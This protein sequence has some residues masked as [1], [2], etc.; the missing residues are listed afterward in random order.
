[1]ELVREYAEDNSEQA[2]ATLVSQHVNLVYSVALR[3]V[4]DPHLAEEIT[5]GVFIILAR[6]AKSLSPKTILSG[7]LCRTAR[8]V[9]AHTL[10]DQRRRQ[11]REQEAQMQSTL[12]ESAPTEWHQMAPL[13]DEALG[14][15]GEKEQDAVML[16][17]FEGKELSRVGAAMGIREDAARMRVNRGLEKLRKF[18]INKGVTLSTA[19]I[20]GAVAANSVR[21]VPVGLAV[22]ITAVAISGTTITSA[23]VIA[24]TKT[25]AMTTLQ[26]MATATVIV[27]AVVM[28]MYLAIRN[29][30]QSADVSIGDAQTSTVPYTV[31]FAVQ[32]QWH[33]GN[34]I[35]QDERLEVR[36][37]VDA[38]HILV[39]ARSPTNEMVG[40]MTW[41]TSPFRTQEWIL[42]LPVFYS[43]TNAFGSIPF[44]TLMID[45]RP[46]IPAM[47][48]LTRLA[49]FLYVPT[50]HKTF[51]GCSPRD[52]LGNAGDSFGYIPTEL[53]F[54]IHHQAFDARSLPVEI[55]TYSP[56]YF[57]KYAPVKIPLEKPPLWLSR[58]LLNHKSKASFEGPPFDR[59]L[60][61][62]SVQQYTNWSSLLLPMRFHYKRYG[63]PITRAKLGSDTVIASIDGVLTSITQGAAADIR[64]QLQPR[65]SVVD[66]RP[67]QAL[68][69]TPARY[70][71]ECGQWPVL[72]TAE[73]RNMVRTN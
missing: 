72:G 69:G 36:V 47:D 29:S 65:V 20:A 32:S 60:W 66:F 26:K 70:Q 39:Q 46:Y 54:Q 61:E 71:V 16:R 9:S 37:S 52:I 58:R 45:Q 10:R 55:A 64:P 43:A 19:T 68:Y 8:N 56:K 44:D 1:M 11:F 50:T 7:W 34:Q 35:K 25:F 59:K 31:E 41:A 49:L 63:D 38:N 15:L 57:Y 18:F 24:A 28:G 67:Q 51:R 48:E 30:R 4:R 22:K 6:K 27:A 12:N 2:F 14:C 5:Q 53:D 73:Y 40:P 23:A 13:L 3:Q 17:F 33:V 62:L 21:A 42:A